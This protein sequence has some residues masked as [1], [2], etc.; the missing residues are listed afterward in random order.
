MLAGVAA[1]VVV[2]KEDG[3]LEVAAVAAAEGLGPCAAETGVRT[4]AAGSGCSGATRPT[5]TALGLAAE[6]VAAG[7]GSSSFV[8]VRDLDLGCAAERWRV[9]G[10]A[11]SVG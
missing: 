4:A 7:T 3:L 2:E 8:A 10:L 9:E 1:R 6:L 5:G 11:R